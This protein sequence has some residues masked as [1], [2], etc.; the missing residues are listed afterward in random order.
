MDLKPDEGCKLLARLLPLFKNK[1]ELLCILNLFILLCMLLAAL[2]PDLMQSHWTYL[3]LIMQTMC[4]FSTER[5]QA[6]V[7]RWNNLKKK[8]HLA[9]STPRNHANLLQS[10]NTVRRT[11]LCRSNMYVNKLHSWIQ[12]VY[13]NQLYSTGPYT[14]PCCP[15][16]GFSQVK[17]IKWVHK[18][19]GHA[20]FA[21]C[22]NR[23]QL[24]F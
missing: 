3:Q 21:S 23:T 5:A 10:G 11:N 1:K 18:N 7:L 24:F 15:C 22:A 20:L 14:Y 6:W 17:P 12:I 19:R 13:S 16:F 2:R 9:I 4:W 8:S